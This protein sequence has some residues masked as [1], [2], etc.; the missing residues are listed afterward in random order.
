ML[1]ATVG[2]R[3]TLALAF[4]AI[5]FGAAATER[6][7]FNTAAFRAAQA[8]GAPILVDIAA[9]WCPVCQKQKP[10][11]EAAVKADRFKA[12]KIFHVDF[13]SQKDAVRE[14]G[15]SRQSTLIAYAGAKETGRS[16]GDTN[17]QS[18][19]ALIASSLAR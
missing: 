8:S 9:P 5:S 10:I 14:L 7:P 16:V 18:I 6:L 12:L 15:A 13:D 19:E 4:A 11:I 17:A 3:A 2:R 1:I